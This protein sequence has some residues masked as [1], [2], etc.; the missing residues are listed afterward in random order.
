MEFT[1]E[2]YGYEIN[3]HQVR[4]LYAYGCLLATSVQLTGVMGNMQTKCKLY[5]IFV[6][7]MLI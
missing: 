1:R 5:M 3:L 6:H 4:N 7:S 2:D